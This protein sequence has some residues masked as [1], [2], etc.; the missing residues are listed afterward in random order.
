MSSIKI[1]NSN[2]GVKV[3]VDG[4]EQTR[5]LSAELKIDAGSRTLDLRHCAYGDMSVELKDVRV[6]HVADQPNQG[7]NFLGDL[8]RLEPGPG[9][10]FVLQ[11]EQKIDKDVA[12][13]MSAYIGARLGGAKVL[14]LGNGMKLGCVA[15]P[16]SPKPE[17]TTAAKNIAAQFA[18]G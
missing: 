9:D 3:E 14:V 4:K 16:Q 10:V 12:E 11:C 8:Q 17:P 7:I 5:V 2:C 15:M 1:Y 6:Q 13:A 18:K